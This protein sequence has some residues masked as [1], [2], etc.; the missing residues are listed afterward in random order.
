M[1]CEHCEGAGLL[2]GSTLVDPIICPWCHGFGWL[3]NG[4][5]EIHPLCQRE[6]ELAN[7]ENHV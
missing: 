3:E 5:A 7:Q 1:N 6:I 2:P 4:Q